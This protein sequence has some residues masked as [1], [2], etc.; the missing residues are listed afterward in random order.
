[1]CLAVPV[2][3]TSIDDQMAE[4]EFGGVE[5]RVCITLTP[6]VG[7]GDYV[8]VHTGYAIAVVDEAEAKITL[9]LLAEMELVE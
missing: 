9:D 8:L 4:V 5:R 6:D 1:M 3:I 7:V 2:R